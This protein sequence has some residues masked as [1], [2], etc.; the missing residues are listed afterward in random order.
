[1]DTVIAGK[2]QVVRVLGRGAFG[3]VL[4]A[5]DSELGRPVAVKL[6]HAVHRDRKLLARFRREAAV[7]ARLRSPHVVRVYDH[8]EDGG[9]PFVVYEFLEGDSLRHRL[10]QRRLDRRQVVEWAVQG[11][12]GLAEAHA[13]GVLHRDLKPENVMLRRDTGT[14]V[15]CDFGLAADERAHTILTN[16][17][18]GSMGTP[19]YISLDQ[20]DCRPT[21]ASDQFSWA[22]VIYEMV[23]GHSLRPLDGI[24]QRLVE[25]LA[26]QA[27]ELP[28]E[29]RGLL[30]PLDGPLR[31]AL[32]PDPTRRFPDIRAFG[33]A[34]AEAAQLQGSLLTEEIPSAAAGLP[35]PAVAH[36][37][38]PASPPGRA[39]WPTLATMVFGGLLVGWLGTSTSSPPPPVPVV[40]PPIPG[41]VIDAYRRLA[42]P[43]VDARGE[44]TPRPGDP[45][46]Q[47]WVLDD[48]LPLRWS[49]YLR[50]VTPWLETLSAPGEAPPDL[51]PYLHHLPALLGDLLTRTQEESRKQLLGGAT[52][53]ETLERAVRQRKDLATASGELLRAPH[54]A[55]ALVLACTLQ[56]RQLRPPAADGPGLAER[57]LAHEGDCTLMRW[58]R[59]ELAVAAPTNS[60]PCDQRRALLAQG[61]ACEGPTDP[62]VQAARP[63]VAEACPEGEP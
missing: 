23:T 10:A 6:L 52:G 42:G 51:I 5:T 48:R 50:E 9:R 59:R 17:A 53:A 60:L 57:V 1:M 4:L 47:A 37:P 34:L 16:T 46:H 28:L 22:L 13:A 44:L 62:H 55:A 14:L 35:S 21:A 26:S 40:P 58:A 29:A 33:D 43:L 54:G 7:T 39:R 36:R 11:C 12:A 18:E 63:R 61:E 41:A 56:A 3:S 20:A 32:E 45:A 2:Y 19:L 8:G 25:L 24:F 27:H 31:R 38:L 30:G 49:A 15:L